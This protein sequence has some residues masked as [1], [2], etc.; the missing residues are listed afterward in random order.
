VFH[1]YR[2]L[3]ELRH[4]LP[5]VAEGDFTMLL[6]DDERVYAFTRSLDGV[7]LLVLGNF[8]GDEVTVALDGWED[9]E[10]L[11]GSPGLV[12]GPWEGKAYRRDNGR[13]T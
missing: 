9:A 1:H 10:A 2:R 3:I 7:E 8:S 11:I 13:S 6:E 4:T 12:L 5:V